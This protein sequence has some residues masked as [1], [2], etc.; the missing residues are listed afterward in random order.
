MLHIPILRHGSQYKS[1]DVAQV[2][3]HR[4]REMFVE[5]SQANAGLIRRDLSRQEI[6]RSSLSKLS[7]RDLVDVCSRA[8]DYFTNDPLSIGENTQTPEDYVRQV[9][10]TTGLPYVLARRNM[11]KI[12]SMLA[13]MERVINGLTRNLDWEI[14]DRGFGDLAGRPLSFYPRSQS[15][16]A[17]LPNNSPGVHSL[18]IP[19][20]P[21]RIPLVLKPGSAE[22]WTPVRIIH[23]L[24]KAGAPREAFSFYPTDHAG[25]GEILRSCGRSLVFGDASTTG[26]WENDPRVE[27]HG[28][29]YSKIIIGED[30]IDDWEDYLDVMTSSIAD[31][32]GRSCVNASAIWA[33]AHVDEIS[34]A[35][36]ERLARIVPRAADDENAQLAPFV[37]PL[38]ANRIN[39][40]IDQGLTEPGARD[41]TASH[42][43]GER[44]VRWNNCS[45]LL[46]TIIHCESGHSL[47]MKEFLFPFA[48]VV[49]VDQ[50]ELSKVL[51]P[52]LVVTAITN[53]PKL[54]QT[55]VSLQHIDRLNVGA[56]PT[57]QVSWDQPHE[58]NLFE[59]LY[60]RRAFQHAVAG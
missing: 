56:L 16:G 24:I 43:R 50:D 25:A 46:P 57:N 32:G 1:L 51:R 31:N 42:R 27:I 48:S 60:G 37:D 8:A 17:V 40:I 9:S 49:K 44:L 45:Y 52:S 15:L 33:P 20:F 4:T 18:W 58:G 5:V 10:A 23:A 38:I 19:A 29:G 14:L 12:K 22:P 59:H 3:H 21:L 54:I 53:D 30:C 6:G 13:S 41:V 26:M 47:A 2:V 35:L 34:E 39:A 55:L 36:S 28:P 11:L 7:T